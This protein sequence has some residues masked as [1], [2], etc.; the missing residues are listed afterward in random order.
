MSRYRKLTLIAGATALAFGLAACS[1]SDKAAVTPTPEPEP[2]PQMVCEAA[3][4][5]WSDGACTSAG[6]LAYQAALAA[7]AAAETAEAAQA[8]YD[9]ADLT[10]ITGEQATQLQAALA[11]QLA[12][13][14]TAAREAERAMAFQTA[15]ANI[16]AATTAEAA[17]AAYDAVKDDVTA[18]EGETLQ[19]AVTARIAALEMMARADAQRTALMNAAGAIDTSDLSTQELVDAARAGIVALREALTNAADVSDADKA[20]YMS[21]LDDAVSAVDAAQGGL[22]TA[23]RRANQM[24]ALSSAST[25]LNNALAA[26][27]GSTATQAQLDAADAALAA[28]NAAV[29]GGADLTGDEKAPYEQ[30]AANA[31]API[32]TAKTAKAE[33]DKAAMDAANKA[34]MATAMKLHDGIVARNTVSGAGERDA[35][36]AGDG[37]VNIQVTIGEGES[38]TTTL[39]EN[40]KATVADL[41]G[42]KG[43]MYAD[44]AGGNVYEAVVY[45]NVGKPTKGAKFNSGTGE[46]NVGFALTDGAVT[47]NSELNTA[48]R[49]ASSS[50]D[51]SA[52]HK[53]F[54]LP[55]PNPGGA[56]KITIS[57]SYYG[58]SGTYSCTPSEAANGCRVNRASN[59][60]TLQLD[61][62]G[63][64]T[65]TFAPGD[66]NARV[67]EMVDTA[68]ASYGWWIKKDADGKKVTASAFTDNKGTAPTAL[69]I[70]ALRGTATYRGGAAGKYALYSTTGGTNDAGHFTARATLTATF[71]EDHKIE[72][73]IDQ[74]MGAD[75]MARNWSVTLNETDISDTGVIDGVGGVSND[76]EVGT[77]WAIGETKAAKSGQWRGAL[78]EAGDDGVPMVG[79]GTFYTHYGNDGRMVGAFG[80]TK[81]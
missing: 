70:S 9:A 71:A 12:A 51:H 37:D 1:S 16:A 48:T 21:Q 78:Q 60:Y 28:L 79:T 30:Q 15:L 11:T 31:A 77:V 32:A 3:G 55:D 10:A 44:P 39:T 25:A 49:V 42:W 80:V 41:H 43:K 45:S 22:D 23:T 34:M 58:V 8:A 69:E 19:G 18:S 17:Q 40:K 56:T 65:W 64:G 57:G 52:G 46:G 81:Q 6:D 27:S 4:G 47:I 75:G 74:F 26:L 63:G 33:A 20:M 59:G 62:T 54:K 2:T 35:E 61:G 68:Y 29:T 13:I 66:P 7:I 76:V 14:E 53:T 5:Q 24:A 67:T 72:G 50:F 36:Y 38:S 73:T